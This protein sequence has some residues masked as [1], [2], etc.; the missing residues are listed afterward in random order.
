MNP[1][2]SWNPAPI[3]TTSPF[4]MALGPGQLTVTDTALS[5]SVG[6]SRLILTAEGIVLEAPRIDL[7]PPKE[8]HE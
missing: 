7:N 6:A 3:E 1:L 5:F 2:A 4:V 8:A